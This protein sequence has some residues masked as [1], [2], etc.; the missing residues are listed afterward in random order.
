MTYR[1]VGK[2]PKGLAAD[3]H[4]APRSP[5]LLAVCTAPAT[6]VP[7]LILL[8]SAN[9]ARPASTASARAVVGR[10]PWSGGNEGV[11]VNLSDGARAGR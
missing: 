4:Q 11:V 5:M 1:L 2:T 9:S 10:V 3:R 7:Y 8:L 6:R